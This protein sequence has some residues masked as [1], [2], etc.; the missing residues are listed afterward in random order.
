MG[1]PR[2]TDIIKR[3]KEKIHESPECRIIRGIIKQHNVKWSLPKPHWWPQHIPYKN[4]C[5]LPPGYERTLV[6]TEPQ[7]LPKRRKKNRVD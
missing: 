2:I 7:P 4:I 5:S 6:T 1:D 3:H